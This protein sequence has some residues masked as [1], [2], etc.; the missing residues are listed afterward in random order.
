MS[1]LQRPLGLYYDEIEVGRSW[2]TQ[3]RTVTETDLINF[4][5]FSWDTHP[6]HTDLQFAKSTQFGERL[7]HGPGVF[8]MASGLE[9][10][11]GFKRG[12]S[13]VMLGMTWNLKLP[14]LIGDTIY[15][16]ETVASKRETKKPD[17]GIITFD[18]QVLNQ[19]DEVCHDGQWLVMFMRRPEGMPPAT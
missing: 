4:V 13:L 16:K 18:L 7:M 10:G 17:R 19:R 12:T 8:A 3:R 9:I 1:E 6:M 5:G 2:T 14:V 15:V 11:L